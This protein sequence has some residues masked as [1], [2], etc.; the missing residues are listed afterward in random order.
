MNIFYL[1]FTPLKVEIFDKIVTPNNFKTLELSCIASRRGIS[2]NASGQTNDFKTGTITHLCSLL[3][4]E[5]DTVLYR[6]R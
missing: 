3:F 4:S 6:V 1:S 2:D 5:V